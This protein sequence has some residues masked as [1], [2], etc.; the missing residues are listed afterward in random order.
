MT[1]R[2]KIRSYAIAADGEGP[3]THEDGGSLSLEDRWTPE[4]LLL[5]ALARCAMKSLHYHA[6]RDGLTSALSSTA[7]GVVGPREDGRSWGFLELEC[8]VN[9]MLDPLPGD[10]AGLLARG[11]RGCFVGAS[12]SPKP[13]YRWVVNGEEVG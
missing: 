6:R 1:A 9:A 2:P 8:T 13:R 10:L 3:I 5:T 7:T 11:E 4:H 12:L